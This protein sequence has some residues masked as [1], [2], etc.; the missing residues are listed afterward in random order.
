MGKGGAVNFR[1]RFDWFVLKPLWITFVVLSVYYFIAGAWIVGILMLLMD[2]LL[3]MAA[4]SLH[5]GKSFSQLAAGYPTQ[6]EDSFAN[7]LVSSDPLQFRDIGRAVVK[8]MPILFGS[9][10]FCVG[11]IGGPA[12]MALR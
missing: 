1:A 2:L 4:A 5:R 11:E 8:L 7:E 6:E 10:L 3:G 12:P 9:P